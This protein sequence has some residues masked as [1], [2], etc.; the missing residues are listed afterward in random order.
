MKPNKI[1]SIK[2]RCGCILKDNNQKEL[3]TMKKRNLITRGNKKITF[4]LRMQ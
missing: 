3:I 2:L 1:E 4:R